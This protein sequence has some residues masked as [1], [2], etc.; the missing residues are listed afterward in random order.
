MLPELT[1][2]QIQRQ[3]DVT[4]TANDMKAASKKHQKTWCPTARLLSALSLESR[5]AQIDGPVYIDNRMLGL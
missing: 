5:C 2:L 1:F 3:T 4:H